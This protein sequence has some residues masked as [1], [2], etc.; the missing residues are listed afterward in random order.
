MACKAI[1]CTPHPNIKRFAYRELSAIN[2]L[3]STE[4]YIANFARDA[5]WT[6]ATQ[7]IRLYMEYYDGGDLQGVINECRHQ[8]VLVHPF[9][10]TYWA[11]EVAKGVKACHERGIIHRD[12]KPANVLLAMRFKF[13]DMLWAVSNN[14]ELTH[15]QRG[16]AQEFLTWLESRPAWCHITD[17]GLGRLSSVAQFPEHFT[18]ASFLSGGILGTPG[19]MAPETLGSEIKFSQ[20]S[21]IYS[22]GIIQ[23]RNSDIESEYKSI[24]N[25]DTIFHSR[26]NDTANSPRGYKAGGASPVG[27]PLYLQV[28]PGAS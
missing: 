18:R 17:F 26:R 4:R 28:G 21:D 16:L 13:N 27:S 11:L 3:A 25:P 19:Y 24:A 10:A 1:D 8:S 14:E 9:M 12:L 22:L 5:S 6:D 15:D 7:T 20:K 2:A 23:P